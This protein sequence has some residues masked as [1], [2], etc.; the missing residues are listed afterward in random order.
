M[1]KTLNMAII[2]EGSKREIRRSAIKAVSIPG[3]QVPFGSRELPMVPKITQ[4]SEGG[5]Y[6]A[7]FL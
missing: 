3:Y 4:G 7:N 2:D 5:Y 1:E 6:A